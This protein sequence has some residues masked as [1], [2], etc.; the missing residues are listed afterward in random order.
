MSSEARD[1]C[2]HGMRRSCF[3]Q[4]ARQVPNSAC[5]ARLFSDNFYQVVC[6]HSGR[7][8]QGDAFARQ[9][10][11]FPRPHRQLQYQPPRPSRCSLYQSNAS[12]SCYWCPGGIWSEIFRLC[13]LPKAVSVQACW[14]ADEA[15]TPEL[16][17]VS[18]PEMQ[19]WMPDAQKN[20]SSMCHA[21]SLQK[22]LTALLPV[23][24]VGARVGLG[25]KWLGF[26]K[27]R[28]CAACWPAG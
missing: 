20:M 21:V 7:P 25:Q 16:N 19:W 24:E 2:N 23:H 13:A 11:L 15:R 10:T 9:L 6:M 5:P 27:N 17:T 18:R 3:R 8:R 12:V 28:L 22:L 14:P 26:A 4:Q 1:V